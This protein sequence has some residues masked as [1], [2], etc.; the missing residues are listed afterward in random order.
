[1]YGRVEWWTVYSAH[2]FY[3]LN[4][5][6]TNIS[7]FYRRY[8][9]NCWLIFPPH[10]RS[11]ILFP[12]DGASSQY[13]NFVYVTIWTEHFQTGGKHGGSVT[14]PLRSPDL[15]LMDFF[16]SG[17][18]KNLVYDTLVNS[19][20][21]LVARISIA[22][23][24]IIETPGIFEHVRQFMFH[25]YQACI[26]V[27]DWNFEYFLRCFYACDVFCVCIYVIKHFTLHSMLWPYSLCV[28]LSH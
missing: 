14:W 20:M 22:A 28:S 26:H 6:L 4:W 5:T 27:S 8:F 24:M 25:R 18:I 9:R 15:S 16:L 23:T 3:H 7:S 21:D 17:A 2:T 13:G 12:Q 1:M 11:R 19:E 10:V